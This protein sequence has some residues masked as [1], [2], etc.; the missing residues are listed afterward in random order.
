MIEPESGTYTEYI[1]V[2]ITGTEGTVYAVCNSD[3]PAEETDIYTGP[4]S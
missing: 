4:I 1:D 2:T 3:F